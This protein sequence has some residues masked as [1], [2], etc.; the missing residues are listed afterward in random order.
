MG[1]CCGEDFYSCIEWIAL[2]VTENPNQKGPDIRIRSRFTSMEKYINS[3]YLQTTDH[4]KSLP[5][6][7]GESHVVPACSWLLDIPLI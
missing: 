2:R 1:K 6:G 7:K 3:S 5:M 4:S